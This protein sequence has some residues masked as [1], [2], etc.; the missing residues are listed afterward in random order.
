MVAARLLPLILVLLAAAPAHAQTPTG[1]I[2][3]LVTDPSGAAVAATPIQIVHAATGQRR[4]VVTSTEGRYVAELLLPGVYLV[5]IEVTGFKRLETTATVESGTSTTADLRLEIGDL[6]DGVIVRAAEPRLRSADHHVSGVVRR[7]QI[8]SLPL[9]GRN[10]L[11]LAK[12]EPGVTNPFRG[13]DN[14]VFVSF[15]GSG[16]QTIPRIGYSR[17]AV[18]GANI[19]TP[20]TAGVLF[21]VSQDAAQEFQI[22][23]ANFDA[24]TSMAS[25]GSINI[26]TRSG[27]N[28]PHGS[29]FL[30][31]RDH[32]LAAYPGL[33]R[34]PANPD[35]FFR[36]AQFG[37]EAGGPIRT[38]RLFFFVAYERHDQKGVASIQSPAPEFTSR[39]GIFATPY[40]GNQFTVRTDGRL[41]PNH[42]AFV[43]YTHDGNRL[44]GP[45]TALPSAWQSRTNGLGQGIGA[46]TSVLSPQVVNDV[47]V[48]YFF[49]DTVQAPPTADQ[50]RGCFGLGSPPIS[51]SGA[52]IAFGNADR[53]S[54]GGARFQLTDSLVWQK[55]NHRL[56]FAFDW[57][58]VTNT[59]SNEFEPIRM[60]LWSPARARQDPS[61]PLPTSFA[62][63]DAILQLPLQSVSFSV[64]SGGASWR[65]F[66]PRRVADLFRL[67]VS[68]TWPVGRRLTI[69]SGLSWSY[70]PNAL[71]HDLTKPALLAPILG[72]D[73]LDA[74]P[75]QL[76][77]VSPTVGFAWAAT[78]DGKTVV[79]GGAGRYFD[80]VVSTNFN[81][82]I[83][84]R[85]LLA[86]LGTGRVSVD[87]SSIAW[88]GRT[89]DFRDRP[90]A[91]RGTD[92]LNDWRAIYA[93]LERSRRPGNRDFA[94]RNLDL[95]KA[96][97]SL[98]DPAYK[99]PYAIHLG[100]G[101]QRELTSRT[102]IGADFVWKKFINTYINGIDYN[103]WDSASGPVLPA[104]SGEQRT[105]VTA[106]CSRG[107][108]FFDTTI[109]RARYAGL[110]VR[111]DHRFA[112][113]G[114]VLVSYALGSYVGSNGTGVGTTENPGGRVFGFNNDDWSEN[115]GPLPTDRRHVLNVSGTLD[116]PSRL[117][118]AGSMSAYSRTPFAP[119]VGDV[120]FNGDG[121]V[122]DLLPGTSVNQFARSLDKADLERLVEQYNATFANKDT[123]GGQ[124]APTLRLPANYAFDDV[125]FTQDLRI[126]RA[127]SF[128]ASALRLLL[129]G[130]VFNLFNTAN[131]VQYG[132][133]L[134]VPTSFGQPLGRFTQIFGSGGPRAFQLG[135]KLSF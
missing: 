119:Y 127:F 118:V 103:R 124:T 11:E 83:N 74:P 106:V 88:Q 98:Y 36:R 123:L 101:V 75:V 1:V 61:I 5:S 29:G 102:V 33:R 100:V 78:E 128:G 34:D 14:R 120:D 56:R 131:L 93:E 134:T 12:L 30:S 22:A 70:E 111:A 72:V 122:D 52:G 53:F 81:S 94:V 17:A 96:G 42:T 32:H 55:G 31:Y 23:T 51:I 108:L 28:E 107:R 67:S 104:C 91:F 57:E 58:H 109:G 87:G 80:P 85:D 3:G 21:Q 135:T 44:F 76:G 35:P 10:F 41:T 95:T 27:G 7:E 64:G 24:S 82:L 66:G 114:Q 110:L 69:N 25:N 116:L 43:R 121:T 90:T 105:D 18:D 99:T 15:L 126:S 39:G 8:D 45:G 2:V 60:V 86:P 19:V 97:Q 77:N 125:F 132:S 16:L 68:D 112:E 50:C 92:L 84:E 115:Y 59:V 37:A 40:V 46:L 63:I 130:E 117:Q 79:R 62:T 89:L 71:N 133:D 54:F 47:R 9:N 113:R 73:N 48:S 38:D 49:F 26:V 65:D 4:A 6:S 20:G 129:F 13:G